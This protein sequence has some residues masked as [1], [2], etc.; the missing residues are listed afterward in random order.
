MKLRLSFYQRVLRLV[1][2]LVC[3]Y[4]VYWGWIWRR[5]VDEGYVHEALTYFG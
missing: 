4:F 2:R 5:T 1:I 3:E